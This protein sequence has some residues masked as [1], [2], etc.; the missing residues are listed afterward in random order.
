M[1]IRRSPTASARRACRTTTASRLSIGASYKW[2]EKLSF[3]V[4]YTHIF[5]SDTPIRIVP[6]HQ[7]FIAAP[8]RSWRAPF[9]GDV[10]ARVDIFSV[11]LKYRWDTPAIPIPAQ[12]VVRKG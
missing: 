7:D 9:V 5:V 1:R 11:G 10:D 4:A 8:A 3:D 6:G 2:N 12:P